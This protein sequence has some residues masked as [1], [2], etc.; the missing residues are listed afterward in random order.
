MNTYELKREIG[1][2]SA[3]VLVVANMVGTGIFTTSGFVIQELGNPQTMLLCWFFGGIFAL[4]GA[5]CYGELGALFPKPGGEYVFLRE[6]FGNLMGFL[7]GWI[8]LFVGFSAPIA[9]AAVAFSTYVFRTFP[10]IPEFEITLSLMGIS[11]FKI[12]SISISAT[13]VIIIFS[14]VHSHSIFIG[15]RIQNGLTL[16][17][18]GLIIVFVLVGLGLGCGSP[19]HFSKNVEFGAVFQAN[20]AIS[21]IFISFAYSG[22][23]TAVYPDNESLPSEKGIWQQKDIV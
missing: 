23:N 15:S 19:S 9:A 14:L 18:V 4:C 3:T 10:L 20:F 7:S 1:G 21:L 22:W 11:I 16:F 12:S 5:L 6:S 2:G 8:S 13:S 17:K